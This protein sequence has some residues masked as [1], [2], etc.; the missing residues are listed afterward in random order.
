M[1][2]YSI[3]ISRSA[4]TIEDHLPHRQLQLLSCPV[5]LS[6]RIT[7]RNRG[8]DP[9]QGMYFFSNVRM[10]SRVYIWS[11]RKN[12]HKGQLLKMTMRTFCEQYKSSNPL[13]KRRTQ[14]FKGQLRSVSSFTQRMCYSRRSE[15]ALP[16]KGRS[17]RGNSNLLR[18]CS[19]SSS[20][21]HRL[22]LRF[23]KSMGS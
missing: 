6:T 14:G 10:P 19:K 4:D 15:S 9:V 8:E 17:L 22:T 3:S 23:K 18:R 11:L 20:R 2:R 5:V 7:N 16:W 21:S 12:V 1:K 13:N